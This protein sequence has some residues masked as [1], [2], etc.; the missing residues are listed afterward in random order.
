MH[1]PTNRD[2]LTAV[3][4]MQADMLGRF[5][6]QGDR[7]DGVDRRF[8]ALERRFDQ[9]D[10]VLAQHS[11]ALNELATEMRVVTRALRDHERRIT[12]LEHGG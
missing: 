6:L 12:A 7:F 9:T 10:V 2:I 5:A 4:R 8:D 3:Q 1:E 11:M